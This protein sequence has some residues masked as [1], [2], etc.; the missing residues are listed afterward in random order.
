MPVYKNI[1]GFSEPV[2]G[3]TDYKKLPKAAQNYV[4]FL[5]KEV[6]VPMALISMGRSRD[7]TILVDKKFRWI[8]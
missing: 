2:K 4:A 3:I 1:P 8:P 6:G 7:E 5:A